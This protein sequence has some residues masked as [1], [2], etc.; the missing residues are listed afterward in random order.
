MSNS[1]STVLILAPL[2]GQFAVLKPVKQSSFA[3]LANTY[4]LGPAINITGASQTNPVV[5]T[6]MTP[7]GYSNGNQVFV[8]G[9]VGMTP[10]NGR[11]FTIANAVGST[12]ELVGEDGTGYSAYI[13]G[14]TVQK[15]L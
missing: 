8:T 13:S 14:G 4:L 2:P 10:L 11:S 9:I 12:F 7:H 1:V 15:L 6:T 5:I 3:S